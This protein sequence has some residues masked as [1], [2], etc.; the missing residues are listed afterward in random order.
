MSDTEVQLVPENGAGWVIM[1]HPDTPG[2][3]DNPR[4]RAE[5]T[6]EAFEQVWKGKGWQII[7]TY[8]D[9]SAGASAKEAL[10]QF[11]KDELLERAGDLD[12]AGATTKSEIA[13]VLVA[14][15]DLGGEES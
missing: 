3:K 1:W 8:A 6:Q 15:G 7:G 14:H 12:L 10:M 2:E 13:D 4:A 11:T 9:S 5:V